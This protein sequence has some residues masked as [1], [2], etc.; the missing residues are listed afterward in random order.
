MQGLLDL[1]FLMKQLIVKDMNRTFSGYSLQGQQKNKDSMAGLSKNVLLP[2]L[3]VCLYKL[4]VMS[5]GTEISAMVFGQHIH[6]TLILVIFSSV[7]LQ[8][9]KFTTV[10][11]GQNK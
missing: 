7:V 8:R 10:N 5:S 6:L 2:T 11:P 9:T 3:H 4:C 1:H